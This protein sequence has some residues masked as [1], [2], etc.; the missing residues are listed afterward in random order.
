MFIRVFEKLSKDFKSKK[1][2][3]P[4]F[5]IDLIILC[6]EEQKVKVD[7]KTTQVLK[8]CINTHIEPL[9]KGWKTYW[10]K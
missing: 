8:A 6:K 3:D 7:K 1:Y 2:L 5:L 10:V 9:S 4:Q